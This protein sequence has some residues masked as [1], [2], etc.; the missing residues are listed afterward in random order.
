MPTDTENVRYSGWIGSQRCIGKRPI[1]DR[2]TKLAAIS[3]LCFDR[4]VPGIFSRFVAGE[5]VE[6]RLAAVLAADVAGQDPGLTST[7]SSGQVESAQCDY[8]RPLMR[9]RDVIQLLNRAISTWSGLATTFLASVL[10]VASPAT[11]NS[12][13]A[14]KPIHIGV[15]SFAEPALRSHLDQSLIRG[16]REQ[17]YVEGTNLTIE[18]RY[19]DGD[20]GRVPQ[21]AKD[22]AGMKLDAIVTTCTPTTRAMAAAAPETPIVMAGVS[23]PIGQGLIASY[24]HP[25]GRITGTATQ[26]EDMA[27]K[28]FQ[29]LHEAAPK[30]VSIAV[31]FNPNNP[32]HK[33]FLHDIEN[34]AQ[35]LGLKLETFPIVQPDSIDTAFEGMRSASTDA[36]MVL[37]D[38]SYLFN[39]RRRII[40]KF[41]AAKL[42]SMFGLREAVEDGGLMSYGES[43]SRSHFRAA[44]YVDHVVSGT[45]PADMPVEQPTKFELVINLTTAKALGLTV[46]PQLL[47]R[48]D[49]VIE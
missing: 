8:W 47:S 20:R 37:P 38:D 34:G 49:E 48:V 30:A 44:Y 12:G 16:L 23:D 24:R 36:A 45:T 27:A 33:V 41:N 6:R 3:T 26:F 32:V 4:P 46:P 40:A 21:A 35:V 11:S 31:L 10:S 43:L 17:G 7:P 18:W 9:R 39:L 13:E 42:P 14:K 28:M 19:A 5:R 15:I 1:C 2:A 25:G 29:L 22:L